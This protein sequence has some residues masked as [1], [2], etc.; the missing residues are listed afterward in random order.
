MMPLSLA[1]S[2]LLSLSAFAS[3]TAP[4]AAEPRLQGTFIQFQKWML[5]MKRDAWT[6]ELTAMRDAGI[7]TIVLQWEKYDS[8]RFYPGYLN[9]G[10]DP[11]E[12][13]LDFADAN[14]MKVLVGLHFESAWWKEWDN[15]DFLASAARKNARIA[16]RIW[17][18]YGRHASFAG[19]YIPFEMNDADY[20]LETIESYRAFLRKISDACKELSGSASTVAMSVYFQGRISATGM[21]ALYSRILKGAGID[22][23]MVQDGVGANSWDDLITAFVPR[24]MRALQ[25]AAREAGAETWLVAE[26][27]ASV[28]DAAGNSVREPV[29]VDRLQEQLRWGAPFADR[30]LTFDFFHYMS[31][32]RGAAQK[33]LYDDYLKLVR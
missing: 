9:L 33:K 12:Y 1:F 21:G 2:A 23:L 19:W 15:E 4:K 6:R 10:R 32:Y 3:P 27:F 11:T 26:A 5:E 17:K 20:E 22:V 18:R 30:V 24:Y 7:T 13:V 8:E 16:K 14:G 29:R 31:P 28:K 25:K